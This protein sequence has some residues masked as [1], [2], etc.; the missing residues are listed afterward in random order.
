MFHFLLVGVYTGLD[1]YK[2]YLK[3]I[4]YFVLMETYSA[5][6]AYILFF[7]LSF[8]FIVMRFIYNT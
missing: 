5:C 2:C 3:I 1:Y 6:I 4:L 7:Y 8:P